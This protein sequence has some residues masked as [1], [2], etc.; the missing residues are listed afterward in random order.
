MADSRKYKVKK[1]ENLP[2]VFTKQLGNSYNQAQVVQNTEGEL[3]TVKKKTK[4]KLAGVHFHFGYL[5][6]LPMI[7]VIVL[8]I[9]CFIW[10]CGMDCQLFL[11]LLN[12]V[13]IIIL[14]VICTEDFEFKPFIELDLEDK[15]KEKVEP[16]KVKHP[17]ELE[18]QS[19]QFL[20]GTK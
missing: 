3:V 1:K 4:R 11:G 10:G 15:T 9:L 7:A 2:L 18:T 19:E 14:A 8:H 20:E 5:L 16:F 13:F 6:L 17:S 12:C